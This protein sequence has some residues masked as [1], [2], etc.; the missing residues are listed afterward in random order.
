MILVVS[1]S[2]NPESTSRAL[3]QHAFN[4][5]K[6]S[7]AETQWLDLQEIQLPFCNASTCYSDKNAQQVAK[8]L[9]AADCILLAS[10]VYNFDVSATA[11]NLVE[12]TGKNA[13][14]EK[15]V[16]FLLAAGGQGSYMSVMP[17]A[18]SLMLDFRCL[19]I[20]RFVYVAGDVTSDGEVREPEI[21]KR[22]DDLT[23]EAVRLTSAL[24]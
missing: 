19:I 3:A 9:A 15:I 5:L 20:P 24:R 22:I 7:G 23:E 10:P 12:L 14:A 16:G 13:W 8:Q 17:F 18:N 4:T 2:L 1:T 21:A 6:T 11:K